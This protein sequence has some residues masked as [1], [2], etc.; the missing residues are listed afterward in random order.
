ME[1]LRVTALVGVLDVVWFR[2]RL[3]TRLDSMS[4]DYS[5]TH[6]EFSS[7]SKSSKEHSADGLSLMMFEVG[8]TSYAIDLSLVSELTFM[9]SHVLTPISVVPTEHVLGILNIRGEIILAVDLAGYL[10]HECSKAISEKMAIIMDYQGKKNAY[11][12][13][14]IDRNLNIT[15]ND[16]ITKK[17]DQIAPVVS[18]YVLRNSRIVQILDFKMVYGD[19]LGSHQPFSKAN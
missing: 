3:T 2:V 14:E 17:Q 6:P 15:W 13:S 10:G 16:V 8:D 19:I 18:G 9:G 7:D 1:I 12:V 5:M 11:V 4:G